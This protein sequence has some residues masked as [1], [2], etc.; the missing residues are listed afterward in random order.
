MAR[1]SQTITA[2]ATRSVRW[3]LL[4]PLGALFVVALNE[5]VL[6]TELYTGASNIAGGNPPVPVLL[7]GT[8]LLPLRRLLRL[9]ETEWLAFYLFACF[10]L[11]PVPYGGVRAFF[12]SLTVPLYYAAPDNRLKE[13][14]A[15]LP[16]WWV[17]KDTA[18][19]RGYFEGMEGRIPWEAWLAPLLRWTVFFASLWAMGVGTAKL[20]APLWLAQ[21]RLNFPLAQLPLQMVRGGRTKAFLRPPFRLVWNGVGCAPDC[22]HGAHFLL[23]P[24][25]PLLGL[26]A[27]FDRPP[28]PRFASIDPFPAGRRG[29][30]R[31]PCSA[32]GPVFRLV[33]LRRAQAHCPCWRG[34]VRLGSAQGHGHW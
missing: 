16:N 12:P 6:R 8:C 18:I 2:E 20:F 9:T 34:G 10:A 32:G 28:L 14:W 15:L 29:W 5:W 22:H 11:L 17:P 31:L 21:E 19:I 23:P 26:S 25:H 30:F 33:L 1:V 24:R 13:F 27:L 3:G 7:A 4:F